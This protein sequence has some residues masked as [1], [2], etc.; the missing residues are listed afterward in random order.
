MSLRDEAV[1][2]VIEIV[3]VQ[4]SEDYDNPE[5]L[6]LAWTVCP[7]YNI[8]QIM[9]DYNPEGIFNQPSKRIHLFEGSPQV[10]LT[11]ISGP[12]ESCEGLYKQ[13]VSRILECYLQTHEKMSPVFDFT[14]EYVFM[15]RNDDFPGLEREP[16]G[17]LSQLAKP[18][19]SQKYAVML[20]RISISFGEKAEQI[21][22]AIIDLTT[23]DWVFHLN[24]TMDQFLKT[25]KMEIIERRLKIGLHNGFTYV[26]EPYCMS[27]IAKD[28]LMSKSHSLRRRLGTGW[29]SEDSIKSEMDTFI[30]R[31]TVKLDR[32]FNHK[33]MAVV[34]CVYYVIGIRNPDMT[35]EMSK[36]EM[37]CWGAWSPNDLR[38]ADRIAVP[39]IGGPNPNPDHH[40]C[41][42]N[43]LRIREHDKDNFVANDGMPRIELNFQCTPIKTPT[44][45]GSFSV[46]DRA[47]AHKAPQSVEN[48][49]IQMPS[50]EPEPAPTSPPAAAHIDS[51]D[52]LSEEIEEDFSRPRKQVEMDTPKSSGRVAK[53]ESY[54]ET[55][56]RVLAISRQ[57]YVLISQFKFHEITD[58][59][60]NAPVLIEVD[61]S[62][63]FNVEEELN[64]RLAVNE[65]FI[66]FLGV[67]GSVLEISKAVILKVLI[68]NS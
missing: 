1:N 32:I 21:E 60:G 43:L 61:D 48:E 10:L 62:R 44:R 40:L 13:G 68:L 11:H 4:P 47:D 18:N 45:R 53:V 56:T 42:K 54:A 2:I 31:N 55:V 24:Q 51:R 65:V 34:F 66:Q 35:V 27:M 22:K 5:L 17:K 12:L 33:A 16:S 30:V 59:N 14:P 8:G 50:P 3:E 28:E 23:Q 41:F 29:V 57:C 49:I 19:I 15:T 6:T 46:A 67:K 63:S 52:F 38:D 39:L 36:T 58:R 37:I 64:D 9:T 20:D 7:V 25:K 26:D